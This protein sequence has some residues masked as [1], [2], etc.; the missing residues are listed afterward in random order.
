[1]SRAAAADRP[2]VDA[3]F[4]LYERWGPYRYDE[5][6]T[7]LD[8]AL[9]TAACATADGAS[10]ALVA[11]A[12]LHDAGHLL[13][14]AASGGAASLDVDHGHEAL[15]AQWLRAL[16]PAAVTGPIA[17]HVRAKRFRC[18]VDS[19]YVARLSAGSTRSLAH[20][21]GPMSPAEARLFQANDGAADAVRLREWDDAGKVEGVAVAAPLASYRSLLDRLARGRG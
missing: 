6:V 10:D 18:A 5:E 16:F 11:A 4:A 7:Q 8:H 15:G 12:L 19:A 3:V 21:G 13:V 1:V 17:L 9:Q 2:T 14:L 20:Q